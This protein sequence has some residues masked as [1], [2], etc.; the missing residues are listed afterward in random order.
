MKGD[1]EN[2]I[3]QVQGREACRCSWKFC[4]LRKKLL[5]MEEDTVVLAPCRAALGRVA[6]LQ[7]EAVWRVQNERGWALVGKDVANKMAEGHKVT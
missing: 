6:M 4:C 7:A 5:K 1:G 2:V 3:L